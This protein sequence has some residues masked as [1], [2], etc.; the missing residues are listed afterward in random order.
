MV[1]KPGILLLFFLSA[2]L[3][4][5]E[6]GDGRGR[7]T[8]H[9]KPLSLTQ[10]CE[11]WRANV[12]LN[13]IQGFG[14][15]PGECGD[16]VGKYMTSAQYES[17]VQRAAE[18]ATSFLTSKYKAGEDGKDAWVFDVD[19]TLLSTVP[20]YQKHH[21]GAVSWCGGDNPSRTTLLQ[22]LKEGEA[23]A[24]DHILD[25]YFEIKGR[26]L[27]IF[28]ISSRE[29][30]MRNATVDNLMKAGFSGW[31]E[32]ILKCKEETY[33]GAQ[34]YKAAQRKKLQEKG[35]RIWGIV[36]DHGKRTFKLPNPMYY[37]S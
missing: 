36:G 27:K 5:M 3:I 24:L 2:Y 10:Y 31:A 1:K 12:E 32:L 34:E 25:L 23:P 30:D 9:K 8:C 37:E 20:Y 35:Y 21:F 18:E 17:D 22:W 26:G 19:D 7:G 14:A 33:Q 6:A 29:E 16:Y 28:L 15:V 13:N 4:G 11:S